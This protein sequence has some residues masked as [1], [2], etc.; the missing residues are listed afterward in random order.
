MKDWNKVG[1]CIYSVDNAFDNSEEIIFRALEE[2]AS[3]WQ[4]A[5]VYYSYGEA[6]KNN[7]YRKNKLLSVNPSFRNDVFWWDLAKRVWQ[8][9]NE[10]GQINEVGFSD[11]ENPQIL[12]YQTS[13]GYYNKHW[14][15]AGHARVFS[16]VLYL[17]DV[18]DGGETYFNNF[19][20]SI[21]PEAGKIIF[22]PANFAY[23]HEAKMPKSNDKFS[24]VTWFNS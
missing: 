11:M 1:P 10:Y 8:F 6:E 13:D 7:N 2:R 3:E 21:K 24:L 12:H 14:D 18:K 9:G 19:D 5:Q 15:D 23:I 4:D 20:I 16:A 22:F 17:N